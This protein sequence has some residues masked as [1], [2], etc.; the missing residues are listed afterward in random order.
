MVESDEEARA[1]FG[2]KNPYR[3]GI[4]PVL[5]VIDNASGQTLRL[6]NLKA[7]YLRP[8]R[9]RV[10]ATPAAEV[11]YASGAR[12]PNVDI[13]PAGPRVSRRKNPLDSW[14]IEG[15]ALAAKLIPAGESASGFVYFQT[16]FQVNSVL[17]ITGI[18]EAG[19]GKE[20]FY[21]EI[22]LRDAR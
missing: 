20:L 14:E 12:K 1:A 18:E 19:T 21:F 8:D 22:P 3:H 2:K 5:V 16:G 15:R 17:Y 9:S 10:E 7:E 11:R 13:G 4:L 6:H